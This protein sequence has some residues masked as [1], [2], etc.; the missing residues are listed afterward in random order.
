MEPARSLPR[1]T[2][3][4]WPGASSRV[5]IPA[6]GCTP[7]NTCAGERVPFDQARPVAAGFEDPQLERGG[8]SGVSMASSPRRSSCW[9]IT[10]PFRSGTRCR[11]RT[12][13]TRSRL[14]DVAVWFGHGAADRA[15]A[16]P[17]RLLAPAVRKLELFE[18]GPTAIVA[19]GSRDGKPGGRVCR[20][21][22]VH[23]RGVQRRRPRARPSQYF[24]E[25]RLE[26]VNG[27]KA[28]MPVDEVTRLFATDVMAEEPR[29]D[30]GGRQPRQAPALHDGVRVPAPARRRDPGRRR[31]R[32]RGGLG[33]RSHEATEAAPGADAAVRRPGAARTRAQVSPSAPRNRARPGQGTLRGRGS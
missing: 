30:P 28:A 29:R 16:A 1:S 2:Q 5:R 6:R 22:P 8:R 27:M 21:P 14:V 24:D 18:P 7:W 25:A 19:S 17:R 11:A 15:A 4:T 31:A 32:D 26:R 13:R 20:L 9:S 23:R 3:T 33:A 12:R 10:P